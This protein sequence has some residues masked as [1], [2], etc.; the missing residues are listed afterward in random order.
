MTRVVTTGLLA[1]GCSAPAPARYADALHADSPCYDVN[2]LD[3]L[4]TV[5][6]EETLDLFDCLNRA[7]HLDAWVGVR[8]AI[9]EPAVSGDAGAVEVARLFDQVD[10]S[11]EGPD[12]NAD[13]ATDLLVEAIGGAPAGTWSAQEPPDPADGVLAPLSTAL[14]ALGAALRADVARTEFLADVL[15]DPETARWVRSVDAVARSSDPLLSDRD[16]WL[17]HLGQSLADA[18]SPGNDRWALATGDSLRDLVA[19]ALAGDDPALSWLAA[20]LASLLGDPSVRA[21]LPGAIVDLALAGHL[22]PAGAQLAWL[23]EVDASGAPLTPDQDS[24]LYRFVRLL[25]SANG[26]VTCEIDLILLQIQFFHVDNLAVSVLSILA[27]LDPDSVSGG[28]DVLGDLLGS[29]LTIA[30]LH[31][32]VDGVD[33][34]CDGLTHDIVDD[35][36]A[37]EAVAGPEA[38]D[39]LALLVTV[40]DTA[41]NGEVDHLA[42]IPDLA[43]PLLDTG[44]LRALEELLRDTAAGPVWTDVVGVL[45]LLLDPA[46]HGLTAADEPA[47]DLADVVDL[48]LWVVDQDATTGTRGWL[49]LQPILDPLLRDDG[50][51]VSVARAGD[52]FADPSSRM[53]TML[54]LVPVWLDADPELSVLPDAAEALRDPAVRDPVLSLLATAPVV[55]A[56]L[57]STPDAGHAETPLGWTGRLLV[58][59]TLDEVLLWLDATT[60]GL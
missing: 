28:V 54:D 15:A 55:E 31:G 43:A 18:R 25:D 47:V 24:A 2:L 58:D 9:G 7:G 5:G 45:P 19:V 11:T 26:P 46:G 33:G 22:G 44:T 49:R 51:W 56:V 12:A 42:D 3:G 6:P 13:G 10:L 36:A 57:A 48:L 52:L 40:L 4:D 29:E 1:W 35:L 14:P 41:Q 17:I 20:P 50:T 37:V 53:S 32:L 16:D 39:L 8:D 34:A 27:D 30:L 38:D 23:V 59:G 60:S 21:A